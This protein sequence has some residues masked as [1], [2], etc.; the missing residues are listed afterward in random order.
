MPQS[1]EPVTGTTDAAGPR[2]VI[3]DDEARLLAEQVAGLT[4]GNYPLAPGLRALAEELGRS[5][6]RSLVLDLARR[7]EAGE[8]FAEALEAEGGR[9]PGHLR[10]LLLAGFRSGRAGVLLGEFVSYSH[11]G[12]ALRRSLW[13]RLAYPI[14][15]LFAFAAVVVLLCTYIVSEFKNIFMNLG[16]DLP[17]ATRFVIQASDTIADHGLRVLAVPWI[18]GIVAWVAGRLLLDR[19]SR[20]RILCALPL[21]GPV[22]RL[23]AMAEFSHYLALLT[24]A[25]LPLTASLPLAAQGAH[26]AVLEE[27]GREMAQAIA[28]GAT[29]AQAAGEAPALPPGF[30]K[31]LAWAEGYQS[32][33]EML[34]MAGEIFEA[35]ARTR[36]A[37]VGSLVTVLTVIL[38]LWGCGFIIG[39]LLL[40]LI[41]LINLLSGA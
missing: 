38:V 21:F 18:V 33:P 3:R 14:I 20:R 25:G 4:A 34:H 24:E 23:T 28:A 2:G 35:H 16:I 19:V 17:L 1:R 15:L 41:Q 6:V 11:V 29:V 40:P 39:A 5:R 30:A 12:A 37:F 10:G 36:A 9:L 8:S 22:W 32:L 27:S 26:D 13:L 31:V 7:L